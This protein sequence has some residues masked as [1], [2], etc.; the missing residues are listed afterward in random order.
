MITDFIRPRVAGTAMAN[1]KDFARLEQQR[2]AS[3]EFWLWGPS[4][5][6]DSVES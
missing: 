5:V 3:E 6:N 1:Q 4:P 2:P